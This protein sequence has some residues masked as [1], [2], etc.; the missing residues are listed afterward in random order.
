MKN[1]D[2]CSDTATSRRGFVRRCLGTGAVLSTLP[3]GRSHAGSAETLP[4]P[5]LS[6]YERKLS[7]TDRMDALGR[8]R[9]WSI[10][11]QGFHPFSPN[12]IV[13]MPAEVGGWPD[14]NKYR[15]LCGPDVRDRIDRRIDEEVED[16]RRRNPGYDP[17]GGWF[18]DSKRESIYW[19]MD[20]MTDH[21]GVRSEFE[22][23]VVGLVG[24]ELLG[25]TAF[26]GSGLAHQYQHGLADIPVDC[27]PVDWWLFLFPEG[28]EWCSLDEKKVH[29]VICHVARDRY[30]A[31][32]GC[33]MLRTWALA[34]GVSRAVDD[35]WQRVSR[36]G[37]V[38]AAWHL[39][40]IVASLLSGLA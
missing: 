23:W 2:D 17:P 20:V 6:D 8:P 5:D 24:R 10:V 25:S 39:N 19:I 29:A 36:L 21:Y 15:S 27:P 35:D 3:S 34:Q 16:T 31:Q 12:R 33:H 30:Y 7:Q 38:E 4:L 26:R 18:P 11:T 37:R 28:I 14:R 13:V 9:S 1:D 40:P 32:Y 22:A